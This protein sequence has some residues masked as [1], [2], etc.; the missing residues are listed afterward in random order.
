[1]SKRILFILLVL[2]LPS[3]FSVYEK[4]LLKDWIESGVPFEIENESY[5][6]IHIIQTNST[7]IY[8][9]NGM[10]AVIYMSN[11]SCA[12]EWLY[13]VCQMGVKYEKNGIEVPP[14]IHDSNIEISMKLY[15][16]FSNVDLELVRAFDSEQFYVDEPVDIIATINKTGDE[17]ITNISFIDTYSKNF[18]VVSLGGCTKQGNRIVWKGDLNQSSIHFCRYRITPLKSTKYENKAKLSFK[19]FDKTQTKTYDLPMDVKKN[20]LIINISYENKTYKI[21]DSIKINLTLEAL[22]DL[23]IDELKIWLADSYRIQNK[24][25]ELTGQRTILTYEGGEMPKENITKLFFIVNN[26]LVGE[27]QI[28]VSARYTSNDVVS[29]LYKDITP[30]FIVNAIELDLVELEDRYV[31]R[32]GNPSKDSF[33][34]VEVKVTNLTYELSRLDSKKFKEFNFPF[35]DIEYHAN[36]T[37]RT[38]YGQLLNEKRE[39]NLKEINTTEYTEQTEEII[40][41]EVKKPVTKKEPFKL[42]IKVEWAPILITSGIVVLL[43]IIITLVFSM[44]GKFSGSKLDKEIEDLRLEGDELNR[45]AE[46]IKL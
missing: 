32:L 11:T 30:E 17:D 36:I 27:H 37:Y 13:S 15:L 39:L 33:R 5:K 28:N 9:P 7:I 40:I 23:E 3:V 43:I 18:S 34:D 31:L 20:S 26:T 24:S 10:A 4:V 12:K 22:N 41:E 19:V 46:K 1:M 8:F 42:D 6:A 16:N 2:T 25:P 44:R 21:G 45:E 35:E 29:R 14:Y 38:V